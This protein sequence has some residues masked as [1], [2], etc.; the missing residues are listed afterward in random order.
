MS[1]VVDGAAVTTTSLSV[2][3]GNATDVT[4]TTAFDNAGEYTVTVDDLEL[5][6]VTVESDAED[7]D[8]GN[9][10][11]VDDVGFDDG[12]RWQSRVRP[13]DRPRSGDPRHRCICAAPRIAAVAEVPDSS[14][15]GLGP[16][17]SGRATLTESM[18]R[19][20]SDRSPLLRSVS[21]VE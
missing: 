15:D 1:L 3:A 7:G 18:G 14:S 12:D 10:G 6:N 17:V 20:A 8:D 4:F 13:R 11:T 19:V 5:T 21:L 16:R 9:D 2:D